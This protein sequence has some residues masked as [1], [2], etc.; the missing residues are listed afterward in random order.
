MR[1]IV[2]TGLAALAVWAGESAGEKLYMAK[3]CYGC[4]GV[5]GEGIG[6][7]PALA[8]RPESEL[9]RKLENLR[10]GIGHSD[11]RDMMIPFA[12]ALTPRQMEQ[13]TKFL[14]EACEGG[15]EEETPEDILGG[16]G[17]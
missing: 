10:R 13:I 8:C 14:S 5:S 6:G 15:D 4:H 7:Y 2:L 3:G 12:R 9:M 17:S 11:K 1:R 16:Y